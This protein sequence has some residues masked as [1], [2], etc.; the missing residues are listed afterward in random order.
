MKFLDEYRDA[1][2]VRQL[3]CGHR[4]HHHSAL[5]HH[6]SLRRANAYHRQVW[7]RRASCHRVWSWSMVPVV[8]CA[9][10]RWKLIDRAHAI[11]SRPE[12]MFCSFGDM[13]RVP[14]SHGD[15]L[16]LKSAGRRYPRRLFAAGRRQPGRSRSR[17]ARSSFSPSASRPPRRP[18]P[19]PSGWRKRRGSQTS[20]CWSRT[21]WCRRHAHCHARSA[22]TIACRVS[23]APVTFALSWAAGSTNPSPP[24][25]RARSSS[26][27][28]SRSICWRAS[29]P[30][31]GNSRTGQAHLENAYARAVRSEGN[32]D[33]RRLIDDVFEVCDRKWRGVG[34]IPRSG[35]RLRP[36]FRRHDA[37]LRFEV[38]DI[39]TEESPLC[40]SGQV[41]KGLKSRTI[42][43]RSASNARRKSRSA[44]PWCL[45]KGLC[46]IS[47]LWPASQRGRP[48]ALS[49]LMPMLE[50]SHSVG[51]QRRDQLGP[52][53]RVRCP[54]EYDHILLGHGSGGRLTAD[55]IQRLFV[56]AFANDILAALEDQATIGAAA[57][58]EASQLRGSPS[59]PIPSWSGRCFFPAA[60]SASWRS[61][62]PSTTW[63]SAVPS[64]CSSRP[65]SFS[66]KACRS[67]TCSA[68]S[69]PCSAACRRRRGHPGHRRHQ[70]GRSRQGRP[71]LHHHVRHRRGARRAVA[72]DPRRPARRPHPGLRHDRRSR[73]RHHVGA[74]RD[75]V[76]DGAG[77][78]LRPADD[79][80]RVMLEA[81]PAIRCDA[82][83]DARRRVQRPQRIGGG[84][85]GGCR[86]GRDGDSG[87]AGGAWRL[88][89]A[90]ARSALR[91]QRGQAARRGARPATPNECW[92]SCGRIPWARGRHHRRGGRPIIRAWS[93]CSRS[94]AASAWSPC[95][96]ENS[97]RGFVSGG[98]R[99]ASAFLWINKLC[100]IGGQDGGRLFEI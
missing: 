74:R 42:A 86:A 82:R 79:L 31:S 15:L 78:R 25:S 8:R 85:A 60:T 28:S 53:V 44:P 100:E 89:D 14:G 65:R 13:L 88:R 69:P 5:G 52:L 64:P 9:S 41:L 23:W 95:W 93:R 66:K 19:W 76:R 29:S 11:A 50:G 34:L 12:V 37:E 63:P 2:A 18:T 84:V 80:T 83:S 92:R 3:A 1:A 24:L 99:G 97:C 94:S 87:P 4:P 90:G 59:R 26:P 54:G 77:K 35:Y 61:T 71:G 33:S 20:A 68:S 10:R 32:P 55:L 81:C 27:V 73:N 91:R 67:P 56:P 45:P 7:Y 47:C 39:A 51:T 36:E 38:E 40:I 57:R 21:C 16:R 70:G 62:A 49:S 22:R 17:S 30:R 48:T 75:R 46:R 72:V 58:I 6:G 43:R 98:E 96:R